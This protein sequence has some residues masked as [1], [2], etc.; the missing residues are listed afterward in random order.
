MAT[1]D[2][3]KPWVPEW[4][5]RIG[6]FLTF[7]PNLF[8][9]GISTA[10]INAAS[11]F[12][13]IDADDVQF[14]LVILY[15]TFVSYFVLEKRFFNYF[16]TK[17]YLFLS[18]SLQLIIVLCT[19][20]TRNYTVLL[21]L[22]FLGG[23]ANVNVASICVA[24]II[25]RLQGDRAIKI[26]YA[27][28]YVIL[29]NIFSA[30]T[31]ITSPF[32]DTVNYNVLYLVAAFLFV[33]GSIYMLVIM[34]RERLRPQTSLEGLD[35]QSAFF[36]VLFLITLSYILVY[37]QQLNWFANKK[38]GYSLAISFFSL[39]LFIVRQC[40]S[41]TPYIDLTI[42]TNKHY[43]VGS[44]LLLVLY[45]ARGA[46]NYTTV[47]FS[48]VLGMDPLHIG[49]ILLFNI[50][51]V[52]GGTLISSRTSH[53]NSFR[54][55]WMAGF[56]CLL[57]YYFWM[58]FLFD[59]YANA[60]TFFLPLFVHGFGTG[61]L[62]TPIVVFMVTSVPVKSGLS[63]I[64]AGI[65]SRLTGTCLSI[66]IINYFTLYNPENHYNRFQD[67][68]SRLNPNLNQN[69]AVFKH[70]YT[71]RQVLT[72]KTG[73]TSLSQLNHHLLLQAELRS[74]MDYHYLIAWML[75]LVIIL[76]GIAPFVPSLKRSLDPTSD[77]PI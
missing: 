61:L 34:T 3:F 11:G 31:F 39:I 62:L 65:F 57:V 18:L 73:A 47:Y 50:L 55:T 53:N 21:M 45:M 16:I 74:A 36:L 69:L 76:I 52:I 35:W 32:L 15:A 2:I 24:M 14:S 63:A 41:Q 64:T 49:R 4:G 23:I 48:D 37:G 56:G 70:N 54:I 12:Y 28:I 33:P 38:I 13:G 59:T 67:N 9:F 26:G 30:I 25:S 17:D 20:S 71:V 46:L 42:F 58:S 51:G 77:V 75:L 72:D 27:V 1:G 43:L 66:A 6:I 40:Y 68:L 7:F 60:S 10:N 44:V 29:L 22:R 5:I 19:Y 8:L